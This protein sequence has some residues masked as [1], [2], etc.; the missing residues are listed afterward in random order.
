MVLSNLRKLFQI[1]SWGLFGDV[2]GMAV[3]LIFPGRMTRKIR[4]LLTLL[5]IRQFPQRDVSVVHLMHDRTGYELL[6]V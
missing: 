1:P 5:L 4:V 3:A 6:S 2:A